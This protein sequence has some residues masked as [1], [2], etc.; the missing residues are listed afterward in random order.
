MALTEIGKQ[1]RQGWTETVRVGTLPVAVLVIADRGIR[2]TVSFVP[3]Q[4]KMM[5]G[6]PSRVV[7]LMNERS[8]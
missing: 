3:P 5:S 6:L 7:R 2:P 1:L 8:L 4:I